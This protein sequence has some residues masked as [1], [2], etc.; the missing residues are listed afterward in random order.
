M[1]PNGFWAIKDR[2][3]KH[4]FL[5][6]LWLFFPPFLFPPK[7]RGKEKRRMIAKI[8]IKISIKDIN[9]QEY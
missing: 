4:E 6:Q 2:A 7:K 1:R 8:V 3:E 5:P 9:N